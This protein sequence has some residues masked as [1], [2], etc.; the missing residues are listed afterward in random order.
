[1]TKY[2]T[3]VELKK[4]E[5]KKVNFEFTG[6]PKS[7]DTTANVI[8]YPVRILQIVHDA[9]CDN[10]KA[11][12][13]EGVRY[14]CTEC[15][16]YNN[17]ETCE[18]LGVHEH[19][20]TKVT[21]IQ[22][23]KRKR[24]GVGGWKS[25]GFAIWGSGGGGFEFG[26]TSNESEGGFSFGSSEQ[27][28]TSA[29]KEEVHTGVRCDGCKMSPIKGTRWKCQECPDFDLCQACHVAGIHSDHH[30]DEYWKPVTTTASSNSPLSIGML[31]PQ[32][33]RP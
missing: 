16:D 7:E 1:M 11:N 33:H 13:I 19:K 12:P 15:D 20:L 5:E 23:K 21:T 31:R 24:E 29:P 18:F 22:P 9:Y 14:R 8:R 17:C 32:I 30:F 3:L 2:L 28:V 25:D 27:T 10:C 26:V 4:L 6:G